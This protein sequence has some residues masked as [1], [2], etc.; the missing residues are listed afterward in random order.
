MNPQRT[1]G[2]VEAGG[3]VKPQIIS[4]RFRTSQAVHAGGQ[5]SCIAW[6]PAAISALALRNTTGRWPTGQQTSATMQLDL[7]DAVAVWEP[8]S[9]SAGAEL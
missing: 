7:P 1:A 9:R 6:A 3:Q 5:G 8:I 2:G 4:P